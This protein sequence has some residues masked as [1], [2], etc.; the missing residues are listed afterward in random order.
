ME[1]HIA[2]GLLPLVND[3]DHYSLLQGYVDYRINVLRGFLEVTRDHHKLTELQGAI[4]EL[5]K[6]QMLKEDAHQGAK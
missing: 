4:A 1:K 6:M 2:K 3:V 5:R